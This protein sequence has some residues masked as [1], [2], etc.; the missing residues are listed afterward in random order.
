[1]RATPAGAVLNKRRYAVGIT[2]TDVDKA[3]DLDLQA[4]IVDDRG[5]I[6]DAV[7][8]NNLSALR[9]AVQHTGDLGQSQDQQGETIW[10][11]FKKLPASI[12]MIIFVIAAYNNARLKDAQHGRIE[13]AA[14]FYGQVIQ[15]YPMKKSTADVDAN[16]MMV[17][18]D[19]GVWRLREVNERADSG[20]HFMD[21]LEPTLGD[22]I[23]ANIPGAPAEQRAVFVMD[24]GAVIDLPPSGLRRLCFTLQGELTNALV[25]VDMDVSAIFYNGKGKHMGAVYCDNPDKFGVVHGGDTAREEDLNINLQAIPSKVHQV[26][27]L[28]HVFTP[29][30]TFADLNSTVVSITDQGLTELARCDVSAAAYETGLVVGRLIRG[31]DGR[32]WNFQSISRFCHGPTWR[33]SLDETA[34]L[35]AMSPQEVQSATAKAKGA[36]HPRLSQTEV[37]KAPTAALLAA[38]EQEEELLDFRRII[39]D[40]F[41]VGAEYA[42]SIAMP[43][44]ASCSSTLVKT[45]RVRYGPIDPELVRLACAVSEDGDESEGSTEFV[46]LLEDDSPLDAPLNASTDADRLVDERAEPVAK[47]AGILDTFANVSEVEETTVPRSWLPFCL[48][49]HCGQTIGNNT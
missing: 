48:A 18:D 3:V 31:R 13:I 38:A 49:G 14:E 21:I 17:K 19:A 47:Q 16:V 35:F 8:Y 34:K 24:K 15:T 12:R 43:L 26:F 37:Q 32:F 45:A 9:G 40:S 22:L 6:V 10:V 29:G 42:R 46:D 2:W 4:V 1:M 11:M 41:P 25:R 5:R 44:P 28:I 30:R 20:Q 27:V 23:R 7:Y 33:E 39:S 36:C